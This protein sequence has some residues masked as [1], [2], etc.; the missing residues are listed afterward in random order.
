MPENGEQ[1]EGKNVIVQEAEPKAS[2]FEFKN[3]EDAGEYIAWKHEVP[4]AVRR[5]VESAMKDAVSTPSGTGLPLTDAFLDTLAECLQK[6]AVPDTATGIDQRV[7]NLLQPF[8]RVETKA[9]YVN[10]FELLTSQDSS[11]KLKTTLYETQL[12]MALE[13]LVEQDLQKLAEDARKRGEQQGEKGEAAPTEPT[14][15]GEQKQKQPKNAVPPTNERAVSSMETGVE[16]GEGPPS[17]FFTVSPYF[18]G[19]YPQHRYTRFDPQTL[20]WEKDKHNFTPA[21]EETIDLQKT[22]VY[23]GTMHGFLPLAIP[24]P[25]DWAF[26]AASFET[27]AP[28]GAA[29]ILRNQDGSWYFRVNAAGVFSYTIRAGPRMTIEEMAPFE[30]MMDLPLPQELKQKIEEL[31][32]Q[33][34]PLIKLKR[35]IVKAVRVHLTYSNNPD[36]L[37]YYKQDP[38][39]YFERIWERKEA[40]CKVA[41]DLACRALLEIDKEFQYIAGFY[42]KEKNESGAAIMHAGNGHAWLEVWDKG[43]ARPLPLDATP[44]GDPTVDEEKQ[45]QELNGEQEDGDYGEQ[46]Q[47]GELFSEKE[48]KEKMK[49][50]E[51]KEGTE[52]EKRKKSAEDP[53]EVRFAGLAECTP[54]QARE[55]FQALERVREIKDERGVPITDLMKQEWRKI[56]EERKIELRDYRGPVRMDRGDRLEDPASAVIDI[57]SGQFNPTGFEV[58]ERVEKTEIDF[59]GINIYFSFDLSGSMNEPDPSTGRRKADVQRDVA[60][61]FIDSIM[62]CSFIARQE[63]SD[64]LPFKIMVTLASDTGKIGLPLTDKWGPKEQWA[65]YRAVTTLAGGGTPTHTTLKLI[66]QDFDKEQQELKKRAIAPEKL[67]IQYTAEISDGTPDDF[68]AT[69]AMHRTLKAKGMVV[70]SYVIGGASQSADAAPPLASFEDLPAIL[71]KDIIEQ[72]K[73]LH[74]RRIH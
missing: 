28:E 44:K 13:W 69:E 41:N 54:A 4:H 26:D 40:D 46:S 8:A 73:K 25:Y 71:A 32:A 49:E 31:R 58:D 53:E 38:Q 63:E 24:L 20:E 59:G 27:N 37:R 5:L 15:T 42:V 72:F 30:T 47:D 48:A 57:R 11:W 62:Q 33:R 67:P 34:L 21:G 7:I 50:L 45:E 66:E 56:V 39:K 36:A 10:L 29:E 64:L 18:G 70:R 61:L 52:K 2:I 3:A 55:F 16:K 65:F 68:S 12:K 6:G 1:G 74:P 43:S 9:G 35:E 22:R 17:A 23:S 51:K 14:D 19:R 60:L